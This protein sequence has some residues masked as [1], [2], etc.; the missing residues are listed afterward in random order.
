MTTYR[1]KAREMVGFNK[2]WDTGNV[3]EA[4][5]EKTVNL[6]EEIPEEEAAVEGEEVQHMNAEEEIGEEKKKQKRILACA[7][8]KKVKKV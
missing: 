2:N 5:E 7:R 8:M 3:V 1:P 4:A 6:Q